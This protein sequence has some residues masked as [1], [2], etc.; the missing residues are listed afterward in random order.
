MLCV[1]VHYVGEATECVYV[2]HMLTIM[3]QFPQGN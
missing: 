1:C 3:R 2:A